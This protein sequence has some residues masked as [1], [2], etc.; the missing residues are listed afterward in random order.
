MNVWLVIPVFDEVATIGEVVRGARRSGPVVVVDDG[1]GD[2]SGDVAA[3]AGA[4]VIR[5]ARR[6]GKGQALRTG[7]TVA[8][9]RGATHV[10]TL[11][12][13]GQHAPEDV[14]TLLAAARQAPGAIIVGS[15]VDAEGEAPQVPAERLNAIRVAGFFVNWASGLSLRDTQSG[16]RVYPLSALDGLTLRRG[17]FVLETEVLVNAAARGLS[18]FEVP[19]T[20]IPRAARRSRFRPV[21]DGISIGVYLAG[22]SLRRWAREARAGAREACGPLTRDRRHARHAAMLEAGAARGDSF[23]AWGLAISAVALHRAGEQILS[24]W[25]HPR[26]RRAAACAGATLTLPVLLPLTLAQALVGRPMPDL[27]TRL[28]RHVFSQ[29][30]LGAV[31]RPGRPR[32]Q[33]DETGASLVTLP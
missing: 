4:E 20:V 33:P 7:F 28:I 14:P 6:L 8:R 3:A 22:Q 16:F 21:A 30:R 1:S 19:I 23:A 32:P 11:D 15:R 24:W 25:R 17:G 10:V 18:V 29:A 27:A 2:R 26:P 9:Q 31:E 5:H 12:G 13:D